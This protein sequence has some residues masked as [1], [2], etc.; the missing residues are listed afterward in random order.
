MGVAMSTAL[1]PYKPTVLL[2]MTLLLAAAG[3]GEKHP[4]AVATPPPVVEV[5]QPVERTVTDYQVFT[6]RTQAVQSVDIK[7]RVTGY[8]TKILFTDGQDVAAGA[9]LF[10]IDDRPYK[11]ALEEAK[12]TLDVAKAAIVKAQAEYDIALDVQKQDK[13]AI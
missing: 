3:C 11:A 8:V 9:V 7:A 12:G 5:A 1:T 13:G 2:V 6:A 10:Q 4:E